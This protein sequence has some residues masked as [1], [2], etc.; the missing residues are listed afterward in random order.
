[1]KRS[2]YAHLI[3]ALVTSTLSA[4]ACGGTTAADSAPSADGGRGDGSDGVSDGGRDAGVRP[5]FAPVDCVN[6]GQRLSALTVT[7]PLDYAELRSE[8]GYGSV[9]GTVDTVLDK[10]GALCRTATDL[11]ACKTAFAAI[12]RPIKL[13]CS[14]PYPCSARYIAYTR[15]DE[16]ATVLPDADL[17]KL[18]APIDSVDEAVFVLAWARPFSCTGSSYR[19]TADGFDIAYSYSKDDCPSSTNERLHEV[20]VHETRD[21]VITTVEDVETVI[22][23]PGY[24]C[25]AARRASGVRY[26]L[27]GY[28][29]DAADWLAG[30]AHLEAASVGSFARLARELAAHGAPGALVRRV[31]GAAREERRHARSLRSLARSA[32][33]RVA[34]A[35]RV[36]RTVRPLEA[37]A[38]E[39]VVEGGTRETWGAVVA[40]VQ[41]RTASS[42]P[43][44]RAFE[45]IARDEASHADLAADVGAWLATRLDASERGARR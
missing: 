30:A 33:K 2:S 13:T 45:V 14:V 5:G 44:R 31:A 24:G 43:V 12:N 23:H 20:L 38:L 25:A 8:D 22:P 29:G 10:A 4:G 39:N 3:T 15:G 32:G 1:M 41:A 17:G 36:A 28:V 34:R 26:D 42:E 6:D 18:A 19:A 21:G 11:A 35:P 27:P 16:V 9:S 37:I 40:A 7:P